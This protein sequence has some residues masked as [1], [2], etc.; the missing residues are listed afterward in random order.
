MPNSKRNLWEGSPT[1]IAYNKDSFK[2]KEKI[3]I[4]Y[5][6]AMPPNFRYKL[7]YNLDNTNSVDISNEVDTTFYA[8]RHILESNVGT[9][10]KHNYQFFL[11]ME[12]T[13]SDVT[14]N[15]TSDLK[16]TVTN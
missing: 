3:E 14:I 15:D 5:N 11:K 10:G 12:S 7:S 9:I 16:F 1:Y 6:F 13:L 2:I 4:I 8:F